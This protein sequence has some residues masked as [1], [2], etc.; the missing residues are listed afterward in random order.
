M[1][2]LQRILFCTIMIIVVACE[3][4]T[5]PGAPTETEGAMMALSLIS[6]AFAEGETIPVNFTCEG[7]DRS[8]VL[9]WS[10][11]PSG[12]QSFALIMDDPDAPRGTFTHWVLFDIPATTQDLPEGVKSV[13]TEGAND[14]GKTGY[15]GPC[16]PRGAGAHRYFFKLYA[17]DVAMLNLQQGAARITVEQAMQ[18][19]ILDQGQLMGRYERR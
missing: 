5:S 3:N 14:F 8:P 18:G 19:H 9:R 6:L 2:T 4:T 11:A 7:Q 15:N 10:A 1:R 13:G 16:P 12:V 17:L